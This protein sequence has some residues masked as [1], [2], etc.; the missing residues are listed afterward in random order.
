MF[1]TKPWREKRNKKA[2]GKGYKAGRRANLI[3]RV[4]EGFIRDF[5]PHNTEEQKSEHA[6]WKEGLKAN[7]RSAFSFPGWTTKPPKPRAKSKASSNTPATTSIYSS[8]ADSS[9]SSPSQASLGSSKE[10][11]AGWW[12]FMAVVLGIVLL[13]VQL[14]QKPSEPHKAKI[15]HRR[16]SHTHTILT[17]QSQTHGSQA[18]DSQRSS[19]QEP[20][21]LQRPPE[22]SAEPAPQPLSSADASAT[23]ANTINEGR[24]E[25]YEPPR[26]TYFARHK[27]GIG[28]C[29]GQVQF[30]S[31]EFR[32]VA[33]KHAL[34]LSRGE[35]KRID[36]P[37][38]VDMSG[39][40]W[41]FRFDGKSDEEATTIFE[42]WF[43]NQ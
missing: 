13:T 3:D 15:T 11:S 20:A 43:N 41:H 30:R 1:D 16:A 36:G 32:F 18:P 8:S 33:G 23:V 42:T 29:D 39:K 35:I 21:T 37:G 22:S 40:K 34:R 26:I 27:H 5:R 9:G 28:G 24:G 2:F 25:A 7:D 12:L 19:S 6:G 4:V 14:V 38:F 10:S 17:D 31:N